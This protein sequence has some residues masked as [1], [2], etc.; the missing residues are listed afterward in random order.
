MI[1]FR[2]PTARAALRSACPAPLGFRIVRRCFGVA[3]CR[4]LAVVRL[5]H[6]VPWYL[7]EYLERNGQLSI[8]T[9]GLEQC[10]LAQPGSL[11][12]GGPRSF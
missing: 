10:S 9:S 12:G 1:P 5:T 8:G 4:F 11:P 3:H 6:T 7:Y 2:S